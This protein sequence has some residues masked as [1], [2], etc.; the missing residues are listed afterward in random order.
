MTEGAYESSGNLSRSSWWLVAKNEGGPLEVLT[1]DGGDTLP[2]FSIEGE[3]ELFLW[4]G[5]AREYGWEV[6]ESSAGELSSL[7]CGPCSGATF[8]ALDPAIEMLDEEV[9]ELLGL[10]RRDFLEWMA[11]GADTAPDAHHGPRTRGRRPWQP[12]RGH[13]ANR[14]YRIRVP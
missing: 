9:A 7:L 11:S 14:G 6:R 4:L 5:E 10:G 3:A 13:A 1:P 8:V 12:A 2:V